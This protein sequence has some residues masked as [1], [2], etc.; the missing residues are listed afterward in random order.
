MLK[1]GLTYRRAVTIGSNTSQPLEDD[2]SGSGPA[3]GK[4]VVYL[5]K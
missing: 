5:L 1:H 2:G 4:V 3:G